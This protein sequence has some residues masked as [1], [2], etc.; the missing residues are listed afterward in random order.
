MIRLLHTADLHLDAPFPALGEREVER[1]R[2]FLRTF[3][4]LVT[5]AIKSE[6]RLFLVAGDLFDRPQPDQAT[7]G[8]VQ[9][10]LKRLVERGIV[11]VLLPGTHDTVRVPNSVF[12]R[13][14]FPGCI[15]LAQPQVDEPV[16]VELDGTSVFLY[17]F[18]Y[19]GGSCDAALA[20]MTRRPGKGLHIGL[21]HGSRTGSP[22]WQISR[23][24][25]PFDSAMVR[26]WQLDYLALG[27]YHGFELLE[28]D[29]R[30]LACYPG[31]PEGKRFGENGPRHAA[32]VTVM[33]GR[34]EVEKCIVN[35][36][37]LEEL[38]LDVAGC[39]SHESL[40]EQVVRLSAPDMLLRLTLA[41]ITEAPL[42]LDRVYE[43]CRSHF[44][45]LELI[46]RTR[47]FDSSLA[48]RLAAE[49]TVRGLFVRNLRAQIDQAS[50]ERRAVLEAAF[51]EA[52]VRFAHYGGGDSA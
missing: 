4:R 49:E 8:Q 42:Q 52:L 34:A 40:C 50:G 36:R 20:T 51:R 27:H 13:E 1:R 24:D 47:L 45:Y 26:G 21:L 46:D 31:S 19:A 44:F 10:G 5:L 7:L 48:A 16:C 3:E 30:V 17:G 32:L 6:V 43:T 28:E 23:K 2:D 35:S 25:I 37:R 14:S 11:P 22:E 41:G 12:R 39:A 18:A 33:A 15:V 29:G 38:T 9:A